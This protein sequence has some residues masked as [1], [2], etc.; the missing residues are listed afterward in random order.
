MLAKGF[1]NMSEAKLDQD[2][3]NTSPESQIS[4]VQGNGLATQS[5]S[6]QRVS[7]QVVQATACS[8]RMPSP[9]MAQRPIVDR[10]IAPGSHHHWARFLFHCF[11]AM[12]NRGRS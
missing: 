9:S 4:E 5:P 1:L 2:R 3:Y 10:D 8:A 12:A 6:K 11:Q 7:V